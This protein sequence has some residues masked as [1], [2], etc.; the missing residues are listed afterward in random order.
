V[1]GALVGEVGTKVMQERDR[2]GQSGFVTAIVRYD[3]GKGRPIGEPRIITH[4]F[5]FTPEAGNLLSQAKEVIRS[6]ATIKPGV[7]SREVEA[8]VERALSHFLYQETRRSPLVRSAV[9]EA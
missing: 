8:R 4:G 3:R 6:A 2:L 1:D 7:V 9:I 5:V